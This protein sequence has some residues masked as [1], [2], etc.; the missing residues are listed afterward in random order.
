MGDVLFEP[1][2]FRS[3]TVKNR[4]LRANISG[5]FDNYDGSGGLSRLRW[6]ESFAAGGVGAIVSSHVPIS[7]QGRVLPSYAMLDRDERIPF[8]RSIGEVVH[9][10]DCKFIVQL[11]HSGR[12]QDMGGIENKH[13]VPMSSSA[14]TDSFH[15]FTSRAMNEADIREVIGQFGAA[16]RRAR[17]AGLDGIELHANNGYLITQFLSSSINRRKDE[18]GGSLRN[19]ARFLLEV[20]EAMRKEV[21]DD[22]HLQ[23]KI[24]A[25]DHGNALMPWEPSGNKLE[26]T[27]EVCQW[28]EQAGVDGLHISNGNSF[29]HPLQP[30]GPLPLAEAAETYGSMLANGSHTF[31]N[32]LLFRY[33]ILRPIFLMLWNRTRPEKIEASNAA[34]TR[35]IKQAV[36]IPV[37]ANGALQQASTIRGLIDD[38]TCDAVT[39]ARPLIANRD[40]PKVFAAGQDQPDRPCTYCNK[41]TVAVLLHPLACYEVDRYGGDHEAIDARGHGSVRSPGTGVDR[42]SCR[43]G[44]SRLTSA[45]D[46]VEP[47]SPRDIYDVVVVGSGFGGAVTACRLAEAGRSVC[48][49]EQGRRWRKEDFPRTPHEVASRVLWKPGSRGLLDYRV[50]RRIDVIQGTGVG[51]GSLVYFN[52]N[53]RAPE[54]VFARPGWPTAITREALDPYYDRSRE[55]LEVRP[56]A[57]PEG[58]AMPERQEAFFRAAERAGREPQLMSLAVHTGPAR[59][60]PVSGVEQSPCDYCGSCMLGCHVHAKNTVDLNYIALAEQNG[61]EV[62]PLHQVRGIEQVEVDGAVAYRVRYRRLHADAHRGSEPSTPDPEREGQVVGRKLVLAAGSL[63][64]TELLLRARD[65]DCTLPRLGPALGQGFSANGDFLLNGTARSDRIVNPTSGPP[66]TSGFDAS[67]EDFVAWISDVGYPTE[68]MW[69]V[70]GTIPFPR[71]I[72]RALAGTWTYLAQTAGLQQPAQ[73]TVALDQFLGWMFSARTLT[74]LAMGADAGNGDMNLRKGRL[75]IRWSHRDSRAVIRHLNKTFRE[76]SAGLGGRYQNGLL[77][78]WPLR[79]LLTAHPLG[80]CRMSDSPEDGVVDPWGGV[81]DHPNLYVADAAVIPTSLGVAPSA[82]IAALAERAAEHIVAGH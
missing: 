42:L 62:F 15:G 80:G 31:R 50:F 7:V 47:G 36:G 2:R 4:I 55:M 53:R 44:T 12:Q 58:R 43:C 52:V 40:L 18:Y 20:V 68:L 75:S 17:E 28:L 27:V 9:R 63:A 46:A 59:K 32:Y 39:I 24:N 56:L 74:Y 79:K 33:R 21:G 73:H 49:L 35:A 81:W 66:I 69:L 10:H 1:L 45:A 76:L 30:P 8:W 78:Q 26:E 64:T 5:R 6:E 65:V 34:D 19:R 51:G 11:T 71:R 54:R 22:F 25:V 13:Y 60:H 41:C 67:T 29:P 14:G 82:T 61:A 16:A 57:P 37:L 23:V 3:L 38:G 70:E 77:W 72:L 48:V